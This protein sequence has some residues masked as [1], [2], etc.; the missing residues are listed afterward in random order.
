MRKS[1]L[2]FF[3]FCAVFILFGCDKAPSKDA[4]KASVKKIMPV[5]FEITEVKKLN[6]ISGLYEV[7]LKLG[8]QVVVFYTDKDARFIVNG[9][10]VEAETKKNLT[11][12]RQMALNPNMMQQ[13][14][15]AAKEEHKNNKK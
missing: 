15:Q 14:T 10:I 9:S 4:I 12:E 6:E 1:V 11:M 7:V 3:V 5:E 8:S 2:A 13:Q